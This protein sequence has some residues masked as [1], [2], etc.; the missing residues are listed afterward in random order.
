MRRL[1]F[2]VAVLGL[3]SLFGACE[4]AASNNAAN[5]PANAAN[6]S[7]NTAAKPGADAAAI[8]TEI[9]KLVGD[10]AANMTKN[11]ADA[12][13]K[14]TTDNYMFVGPN[15]A[16]ATKADRLKSMKSGDTKY[17]SLAYDEVSVRSNPEGTGAIVISRATVKGVNMGQK[18]DG[19]YRVT[20]VW[21]KSDGAWKLVHTQTTPIT[22]SAQSSPSNVAAS[23]SATS[24]HAADIKTNSNK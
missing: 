8:E 6:S 24:N 3:A 4:P 12:F 16:V 22:A 7:A 2:L 9:K 19:Q 17:E 21:R 11:D 10:M 13:D 23:N 14:N 15:G 20:Q 1:F 18:V 5:K